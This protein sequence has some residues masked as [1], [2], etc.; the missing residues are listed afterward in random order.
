MTVSRNHAFCNCHYSIGGHLEGSQCTDV[1]FDGTLVTL[2]DSDRIE[3]NV[4][5]FFFLSSTLSLHNSII[6]LFIY[7]IHMGQVVLTPV[8]S[9]Q[10][11][12][13]VRPPSNLKTNLK[14]T[15]LR[16]NRFGYHNRN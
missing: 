13:K 6:H 5:F 1:L 14:V 3:T 9:Q 15:P 4:Q 10:S 2:F 7:R 16:F 12:P 11:S 8:V